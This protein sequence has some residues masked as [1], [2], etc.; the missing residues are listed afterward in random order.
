MGRR[1][2]N[3]PEKGLPDSLC[4]GAWSE[5]ESGMS[6]AGSQHLTEEMLMAWAQDR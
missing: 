1:T 6:A 5:R 4:V 2:T 3:T